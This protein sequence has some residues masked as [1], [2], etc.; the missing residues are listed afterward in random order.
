[1]HS[2]VAALLRRPDPRTPLAAAQARELL[3]LAP[4][5][6][7]DLLA[8]ARLTASATRRQPFTCGIVNAKSGHC[9]ENCAFCAQSAR[10]RTGAPVYPLMETDDMLRHAE[11]LAEAG[12]ARFG[13]VTSGTALSPAELD[14]LCASLERLRRSVPLRLCGSLGMLTPEAA[15]R[16]KEAGLSRF[17]HNLETAASHFSAICTTHA[18]ADDLATLAAAHDA[19][20]ELCCGGIFGLGESLD[21]RVEFSLTLAELNVDCIPVN[22]LN[23]IPGTPLERQPRLTPDEALRTLAVLRLMHPQRDILVCGGRNSTLGEWD[24]WI[25][26]AGANGLMTGD[27]LT[28]PGSPFERDSRMLAALGL[29]QPRA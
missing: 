28:T 4:E 21:Q 19:G 16:L 18:W 6:T 17:H 15:R 25:F 12:A 24:S 14:R 1:M 11:A 5:H 9:P 10:H 3:D 20:L 2:A 26:A 27:Y 7:L 8:A 29:R 23:P 22:F 13:I